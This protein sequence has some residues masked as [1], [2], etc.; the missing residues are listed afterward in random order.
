MLT[1]VN[2]LIQFT[3]LLQ[4]VNLRL[5]KGYASWNKGAL[6]CPTQTLIPAE[7]ITAS[8]E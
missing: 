3:T 1:I 8:L 5:G 2:I 7:V 4:I 6:L